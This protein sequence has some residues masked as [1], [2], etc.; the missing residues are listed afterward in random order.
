[1]KQEVQSADARVG[2]PCTAKTLAAG[3]RKSFVDVGPVGTSLRSL[4]L[5]GMQ[6]QSAA[7]F[8]PPAYFNIQPRELMEYVVV[9]GTMMLIATYALIIGRFLQRE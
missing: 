6:P 7:P 2:K 4:F 5:C 3:C 1:M 8:D 9:L